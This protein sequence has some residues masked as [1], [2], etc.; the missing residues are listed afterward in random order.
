MPAKLADLRRRGHARRIGH[1][2]RVERLDRRFAVA[3][4]DLLGP[5]LSII[6]FADLVAA[7]PQASTLLRFAAPRDPTGVFGARL[8]G[9][10]RRLGSGRD[11]ASGM[12][13]SSLPDRDT[14]ASHGGKPELTWLVGEHHRVL[15]AGVAERA[16]ITAR[17][18]S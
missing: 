17:F 18:P 14:G 4:G 16:L 10:V 1:H 9:F 13:M 3:V 2:D 11:L 15:Q 5:D 8:L 12:I 7:R 6:A